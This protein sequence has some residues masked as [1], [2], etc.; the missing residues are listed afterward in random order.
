MSISGTVPGEPELYDSDVYAYDFYDFGGKPLYYKNFSDDKCDMYLDKEIIDY[1]VSYR[2]MAVD[3]ENGKILYLC[4][5]SYDDP[6][7]TLKLFNGKA[8]E[9][10]ADDVYTYTLMPNGNVLYLCNYDTV[11][12]K[13]ELHLYKNGESEKL[14]D[15]V[16]EIIYC[17]QNRYSP[18]L[19]GH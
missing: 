10:I 11:Y 15:D 17:Y 2:N 14:E 19:K 6:V 5:W 1:D 13:G 8:P 9:K 12:K 4:D 18:A 3:A 16:Q 7:G